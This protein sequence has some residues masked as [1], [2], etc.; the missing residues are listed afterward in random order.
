MDVDK[1]EKQIGNGNIQ[2]LER[3]EDDVRNLL[4]NAHTT[5]LLLTELDPGK[6]AQL[7]QS[8]EQYHQ[9]LQSVESSLT[10]QINQCREPLVMPLLPIGH[11]NQFIPSDARDIHK[12]LFSQK[13]STRNK[14]TQRNARSRGKQSTK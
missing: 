12:D 10:K 11:K 1:E 14:K 9:L 6:E 2:E 3:I 7:K 8:I 4:Q 13:P 5:M